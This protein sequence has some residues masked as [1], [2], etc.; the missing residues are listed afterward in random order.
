MSRSSESTTCPSWTQSTHNNDREAD[1]LKRDDQPFLTSFSN[2]LDAIKFLSYSDVIYMLR[3]QVIN[4]LVANTC[5]ILS[6]QRYGKTGKIELGNGIL[7]ST[8]LAIQALFSAISFQCPIV[9]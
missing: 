7:Y 8:S 2:M 1:H 5:K 6:K 9:L 4:N 3:P